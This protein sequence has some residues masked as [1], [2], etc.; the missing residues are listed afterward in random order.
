MDRS[1][2]RHGAAFDI[3]RLIAISLTNSAV[4]YIS[5]YAVQGTKLC[6]E[7]IRINSKQKYLP[8]V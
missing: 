5:N 6:S 7:L 8:A 3:A 4:E 1:R 2:Y